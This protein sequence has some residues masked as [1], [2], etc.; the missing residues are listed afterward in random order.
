M[1]KLKVLSDL[2]HYA[3]E[4]LKLTCMNMCAYRNSTI[5]IL[6]YNNSKK[7]FKSVFKKTYSYKLIEQI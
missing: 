7:D 4:T 3:C 1:I 2:L 5:K 6:D